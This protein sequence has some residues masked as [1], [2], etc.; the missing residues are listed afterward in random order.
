L[1]RDRPFVGT[2]DATLL[3]NRSYS[4]T[5]FT[6]KGAAAAT[7]SAAAPRRTT[8]HHAARCLGYPQ[9]FQLAKTHHKISLLDVISRVFPSKFHQIHIYFRF[10]RMKFTLKSCQIVAGISTVCQFHGFFS[11]NCRRVFDVWSNCAPR[12]PLKRSRAARGVAAADFKALKTLFESRNPLSF[13]F[14][15]TSQN[16][17]F[18]SLTRF[19]PLSYFFL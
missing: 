14:Y 8:P 7:R 19:F 11:S 12:M 9:S 10:P 6:L 18:V 17:F 4:H 5:P 3:I 15:Y 13:T 1:R 16:V 2:V